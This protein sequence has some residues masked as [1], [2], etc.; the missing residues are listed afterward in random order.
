[1]TQNECHRE[2]GALFAD[3]GRIGDGFFLEIWKNIP[4]IKNGCGETY[5]NR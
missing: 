2:P 3:I 5:S 1:M 4:E